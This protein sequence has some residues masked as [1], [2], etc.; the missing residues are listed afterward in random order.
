MMKK[1]RIGNFLNGSNLNR[2]FIFSRYTKACYGSVPKYVVHASQRKA[3]A[4]LCRTTQKSFEHHR[5]CIFVQRH[6]LGLV[7]TTFAKCKYEMC[8][9]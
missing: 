7:R 4:G 8:V 1:V 9:L 6:G 2:I 5:S 3:T